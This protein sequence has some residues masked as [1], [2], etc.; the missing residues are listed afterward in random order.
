LLLINYDKQT[1][2]LLDHYE[3][4]HDLADYTSEDYDDSNLSIYTLAYLNDFEL[5]VK[6]LNKEEAE[7][8]C[9]VR[10]LISKGLNNEHE[11]NLLE[12]LDKSIHLKLKVPDHHRFLNRKTQ[13]KD[14]I[15]KGHEKHDHHNHEHNNKMSEFK[16]KSSSSFKRSNVIDHNIKVQ[17]KTSRFV[18]TLNEFEILQVLTFIALRII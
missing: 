14:I 16:P 6:N 4:K 9:R 15:E 18:N 10:V 17:N 3:P 1:N 7:I 2:S 5:L 8:T 11:T 13:N 12:R